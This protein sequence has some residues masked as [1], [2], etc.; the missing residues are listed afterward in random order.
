MLA[1][2]EEYMAEAVSF[3]DHAL[4]SFSLKP[5]ARTRSK[6]R[7]GSWKMNM[8]ILQD[9]EFASIVKEKIEVLS[10][11][12]PLDAC[13][14][15]NFKMELKELAT[16]VSQKRQLERT[17]EKRALVQS[18]K[19]LIVEEE[20]SPGVFLEDIKE[21]KT[22]LL[23]LLEEKLYGAAV[24][25]RTRMLNEEEVPTK[26]FATL[27]RARG[28]RNTILKV[29]KGDAIAEGQTEVGEMFSA[30][31][32]ELFRREDVDND[33]TDS[34]LNDLPQVSEEHKDRM[35]QPISAA[36]VN[37]AI[38]NLPANKAPGPD[39]IGSE[40]YKMFIILLCPILLTVFRDIK[41][42]QLLPPS[43]KESFTVLIPK[44]QTYGKIP[45]VTN[46]RPIS[47]LSTN[48]KIMAKILA[49][50]SDIGLK[51][52]IG[53]HQTY[54]LKGRSI[55]RNL[56]VM[57]FACEATAKG[58]Q[59]LAVLQTDLS[60]AFDRVSHEFLMKVLER[61]GVG[62]VM[63]DSIALCYKSITTRLIINGKKGKPVPVQRSVRQGCPMSPIL[64]ALQ[65]E[66]LCLKVQRNQ[67]ISGLKL[68]GASVKLL[69]V[70]FV[71][72][73]KRQIETV[74]EELE[75]YGRC[76]GE[77]I[78]KNKSKG[79][80]LGEWATKPSEFMGVKWSTGVEKY[81]GV[82]MN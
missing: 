30:V 59:P 81:L 25:S 47:L 69:D 12:T 55:Y 2:V 64:F 15:E 57:R 21:C 38:K 66:P 56:H 43:M 67:S 32:S 78:N 77:R 33:V 35:D 58:H 13:V 60:Q 82:P 51:S 41:E 49:R 36:E 70:S 80:W 72:S 54:G 45:E 3:S 9:E 44:A 14:W 65:L 23:K 27:E 28:E 40:F 76:S 71:C 73:S 42:R 46:F 5:G 50:R 62:D 68:E 74:L 31:Y 26:I 10:N 48:Y 4:V 17:R 29:R 53:E 22:Q 37:W 39:G 6:A 24:R 52:V 19:T 18:L 34:F 61:C 75:S 11:E 16:D 20:Q 8:S 1:R 79:S 63:R 7:D